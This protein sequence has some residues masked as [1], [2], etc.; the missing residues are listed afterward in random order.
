MV[1]EKFE[2]KPMI[3]SALSCTLTT[4]QCCAHFHGLEDQPE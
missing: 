4:H 1:E 3:P 2:L